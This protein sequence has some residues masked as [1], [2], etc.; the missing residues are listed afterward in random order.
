MLIDN[1]FLLRKALMTACDEGG[2]KQF[3]IIADGGTYIIVIY[4]RMLTKR[5][6]YA[7]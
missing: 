1:F 3:P 7:I 4:N 6:Q 5:K 2:S